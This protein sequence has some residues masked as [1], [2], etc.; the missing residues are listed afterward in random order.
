M[1]ILNFKS[2]NFYHTGTM[3]DLPEDAGERFKR[4]DNVVYDEEEKL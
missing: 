1:I 4:I 3:S 2:L